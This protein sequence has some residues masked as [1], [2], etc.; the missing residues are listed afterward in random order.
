MNAEQYENYIKLFQ[1]ISGTDSDAELLSYLL[2]VDPT[3]LVSFIPL[4]D[5]IKFVSLLSVDRLN[6]DK[7]IE[8]ATGELQDFSLGAIQ[9]L[10]P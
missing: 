3:N 5:L 6:R 10:Q 9:E 7:V 8:I 2:A 1:E 4:N